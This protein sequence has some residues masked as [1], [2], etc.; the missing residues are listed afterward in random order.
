MVNPKKIGHVNLEIYLVIDEF[1]SFEELNIDRIAIIKIKSKK[2]LSETN[3]SLL[4]DSKEITINILEENKLKNSNQLPL[5]NSNDPLKGKSTFYNSHLHSDIK[6][7]K[8]INSKIT[9]NTLKK[10]KKSSGFA[11]LFSLCK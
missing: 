1:T 9:S 8:S 10:K 4:T 2:S 7:V 11:L 3:I 6:S 5:K